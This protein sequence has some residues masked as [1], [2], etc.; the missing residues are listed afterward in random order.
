LVAKNFSEAVEAMC[1]GKAHIGALNTFNYLLAHEQNCADV[2]LVATRFGSTFYSGQVVAGVDT[3]IATV[4]DLAGKSF[5]RPDPTSTSGWIIP[6]IAIRAE[7]LDPEKD[8]GEIIDV[9][10]HQNV[11][12]AVYEGKCEA[13][14]SFVDARSQVD[15]PDVNEKVIVITESA[16]IPNDTVSYVQSL[17]KEQRDGL[18]NAFLKLTTTEEG[19]KLLNGP[20]NWEGLEKVD[21]SFYEGFR[22]QLKA[23]NVDIQ[24]L[25]E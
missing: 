19:L 9:D 21:D 13:G 23:A 12:K 17:T 10:G 3:G 1:S 14:A 2:A 5:C 20:Q 18:T 7:G 11:I 6:S 22:Q 16:P 15:F 24:T 4:S 25:V 8:L